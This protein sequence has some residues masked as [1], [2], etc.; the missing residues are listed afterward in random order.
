[1]VKI[2]YKGMNITSLFPGINHLLPL[3]DEKTK[4][5]RKIMARQKANSTDESYATIRAL[6]LAEVGDFLEELVDAR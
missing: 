1:M 4:F 5:R 3:E 2:K 6:H